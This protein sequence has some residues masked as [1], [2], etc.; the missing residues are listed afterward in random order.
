MNIVLAKWTS[1]KDDLEPFPSPFLSSTSHPFA[2]KYF[3][4]FCIPTIK[5]MEKK[6][7]CTTLVKGFL[8]PLQRADEADNVFMFLF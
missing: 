3:P 5:Q 7:K 8:L 6:L 2:P 1:F 4:H